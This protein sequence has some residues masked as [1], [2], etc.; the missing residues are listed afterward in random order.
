MSRHAQFNSALRRDDY[1]DDYD[2]D[3]SSS[4]GSVSNSYTQSPTTSGYLFNRSEGECFAA[5]GRDMFSFH[6]PRV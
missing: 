2:D 1:D 5:V 6:M 3:L 4:Y